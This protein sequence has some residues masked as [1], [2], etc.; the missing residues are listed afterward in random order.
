MTELL[1]AVSRKERRELFLA[2]RRL[3]AR[4]SSS[5]VLD[6]ALPLE[7]SD[8]RHLRIAFE[9]RSEAEETPDEVIGLVQ[10]TSEI[11]SLTQQLE[12]L[13]YY[14]S[15]TSLPNRKRFDDIFAGRLDER[16]ATG[17]ELAFLIVD[18][19]RF[20]EVN[21]ALTHVV[22]DELLRMVGQRIRA[23]L[24]D[25]DEVA[26]VGTRF[27]VLLQDANVARAAQCA[28]A[29]CAAL[30][31]PFQ[32]GGITYEIGAHIG[33]SH[34]PSDDTT[35]PGLLRKADIA[36]EQAAHRGQSVATYDAKID[37]H[38]PYRLGLIGDFRHAAK[39]GEIRLYCQPKIEMRTRTVIGAEVLAR[40]VHPTKGLI[41]PD[42]FVELIEGTELIHV[43]TNYMLAGAAQCALRWEPLGITV[44]LAVNLSTQDVATP[45]LAQYLADLLKTTKIDPRLLELEVT[46]RSLMRN[47]TGSIEE[48]NRLREMGFR[49]SI[50]DF[51][52]GYSSLNYLTQLPVDVIKIDH[53][54]TMKMVHDKRSATIV[55]STIHMAHDLGMTVVA[56]G[57]ADVDIW[58]ALEALDCDEAQGYYIARPMPIE[59]F[60]TWLQSVSKSYQ[61]A[62]SRQQVANHAR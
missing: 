13:S 2:Y 14:D 51:G 26:R 49:L 56:E 5:E 45:A 3:V 54:F 19:T 42:E 46:E 62:S 31:V 10:S 1:R 20:R 21:F 41:A 27:P 61:Y 8:V 40:W 39:N 17:A 36:V 7:E 18:L 22:G 44:P 24:H 32:L 33:I 47:P 53:S 52:T 28:H 57:T 29:I 6:F 23:V 15:V 60:S 35:Y 38:T 43:L 34:C 48:L 16:K 55:R 4:E 11:H 9:L 30:E 58:N 37:R 25:R 12:Q 59:D 50:D